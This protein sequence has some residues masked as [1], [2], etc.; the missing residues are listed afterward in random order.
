MASFRRALEIGVDVLETDVHLTRDGHIVVSHDPTGM[1]VAGV[2]QPIAEATLQQVQSWDAG[3]TFVDARGERPFARAG[4]RIPELVELLEAA[5]EVLLNVDIKQRRPSMVGPVLELL[6]RHGVEHRVVL[7][8]FHTSV[9]REVRARGFGGQT[10]LSRDEVLA[11][12]ALP[13]RL[14]RKLSPMG[15]R[16]QLPLRAGPIDL[17]SRAF[18]EKCHDLGLAV[19][20]WTINDPIEAEVLLDRGADGIMTDDPARLKPVF[21]R[22]Q[23]RAGGR[24]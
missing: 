14:F 21:D 3:R 9:I 6:R 16:V 24:P 19:D 17:A 1:R 15:E 2:P 13:A 10:V 8:S 22:W 4:I 20:Y 11:L 5:G 18:I 23:Q 7:A 12:V